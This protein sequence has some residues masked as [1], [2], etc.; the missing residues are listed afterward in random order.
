MAKHYFLFPFFILVSFFGLSAQSTD[1]PE[2]RWRTIDDET[3][4][5]KSIVEIY[6]QDGAYFGRIAEILT[7]RRDA[8]CEKCSG[9]RKD[10]PVLGMV[11]VE[12]LKPSG[13]YW[14]GGTILDPQKGATYK[15]SAWFEEDPNTLFIRGKHWTGLFRTQKWL[16]E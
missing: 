14:K 2:G 16:R 6:E 8:I 7:N 11:I 5:T 10:Q 12:D 13:D 1:S 15:L 9:E 4:E 3:G